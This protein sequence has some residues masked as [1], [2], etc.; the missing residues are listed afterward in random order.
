MVF[1]NCMSLGNGCTIL[2]SSGY[3]HWFSYVVSDLFLDVGILWIQCPPYIDPCTRFIKR[4]LLNCL[5]AS[6]LFFNIFR[7]TPSFIS[8][9]VYNIYIYFLNQIPYQMIILFN[10]FYKLLNIL[11]WYSIACIKYSVATLHNMY[12]CFFFF[13][14]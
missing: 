3:A 7:M 14:P 8:S 12:N 11:R 4:I 9:V 6:I 13:L 10:T 1:H 2:Y 5:Y